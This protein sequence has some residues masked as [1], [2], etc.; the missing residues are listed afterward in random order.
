MFLAN[1][2]LKKLQPQLMLLQP[3]R[4]LLK[5]PPPLPLQ[6]Q[7]PL[8]QRLPKKQLLQLKVLPLRCLRLIRPPLMPLLL[9]A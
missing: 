4:K 3:K 5:K 8:L 1:R 6:K 2:P 9:L 7:K